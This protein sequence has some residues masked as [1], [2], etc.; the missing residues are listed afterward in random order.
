[1]STYLKTENTDDLGRMVLA[2]LSEVWIMRDR[3][4]ILEDILENKAGLSLDEIDNYVPSPALE[5]R[6]EELR[7]R[8]VGNVI[9]APMVARER[10]VDDI[11]RH[12]G[13]ERPNPTA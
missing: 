3:M 10:E 13:M 11:L 12:A 1:M 8:L 7:S 4:A 9:G 6:L 5:A 2:L